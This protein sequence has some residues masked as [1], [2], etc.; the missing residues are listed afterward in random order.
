MLSAALLCLAGCGAKQ[1]TLS[2]QEQYDLGVRYLSE[3]KYEEAVL[4]FE[5][6]IE[7]DPKRPEAYA[8][9]A[10]AHLATGDEA[11][12]AAALEQGV[13]AT[14]DE[15]LQGRLE[16]LT[17]P[18]SP[19]PSPTPAPADGLFAGPFLAP[20][21]LELM[22]LDLEAAAAL[23][24]ADGLYDPEDVAQTGGDEATWAQ[25]DLVPEGA[26]LA[27]QQTEQGTV[28]WVTTL[29]PAEGDEGGVQFG[30]RDGSTGEY[31]NSVQ[32][33]FYGGVLN[34]ATVYGV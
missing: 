17:P 2:W 8:S 15:G 30:F 21:E 34:Q 9:L 13:A 22:Q 6:A 32:L 28:G 11:A 7:I 4:A 24:R 23:V 5:A 33:A 18:A 29:S 10:D 16:G 14:G 27:V 12:A 20:E 26:T 19:Q 3:G 1:K 31:T 25:L